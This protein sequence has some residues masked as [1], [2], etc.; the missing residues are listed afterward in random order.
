MWARPAVGG[1]DPGGRER[2]PACVPGEQ[3]PDRVGHLVLCRAD[4]QPGGDGT[5]RVGGLPPGPVGV[6]PAER[7][8]GDHLAYPGGQVAGC[9]ARQR[10]RAGHRGV[11][12]TA[13]DRAKAADRLAGDACGDGNRDRAGRGAGGDWQDGDAAVLAVADRLGSSRRRG[14]VVAQQ[15]AVEVYRDHADPGV[16]PARPG[17]SRHGRAR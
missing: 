16:D 14:A 2:T 5:A 17:V 4:A 13:D 6:S 11:G 15:C 7:H 8:G 12:E 1:S 9:V 10:P 3:V